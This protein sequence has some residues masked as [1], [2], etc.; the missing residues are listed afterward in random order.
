MGYI[1]GRFSSLRGLRQQIDDSVDHERAL[2][3]VKACIV[4]HTLV[5]QLETEREDP[6]FT[7]ELV[8]QGLANPAPP[9]AFPEVEV[10]SSARR[11]TR[12][13]RKCTELKT[14]LF[15]SGA[16]ESRE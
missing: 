6:D 1:K 14:K 8:R 7:E 5:G 11:R 12:G 4:I 3:W 16:A 10:V 2:A 15:E 13:Q 9:G